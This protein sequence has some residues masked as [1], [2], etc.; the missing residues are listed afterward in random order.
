[1]KEARD[2]PALLAAWDRPLVLDA[3]GIKSVLTTDSKRRTADGDHAARR[4]VRPSHRRTGITGGSGLPRSGDRS[5]CHPQGFTDVCDG[6]RTMGG[7][8]GT[9]ALA[10]IGTGDVLTGMVAALIASRMP[11]EAAARS[12]AHRH[13]RT[14]RALSA[15]TTVTATGLL[16]GGSGGWR[17]RPSWIEA[18]LAAIHDNVR[19]IAAAV[20]PAEVCAVVKADGYGHGDVPVAEAAPAW[21]H[22][23]RRRIGV[24][25]YRAA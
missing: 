11:P 8:L 17:V 23:T 21:R 10:T 9:E 20:A 22:E 24:R 1:M 3:D 2:L 6:C 25:R 5:G 7:G 15:L 19:A 14:G 16:G 13:G 12:A 18:D 4:R